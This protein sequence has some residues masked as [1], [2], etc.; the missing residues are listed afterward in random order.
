MP[1]GRAAGTGPLVLDTHIWIWLL[2][3][4]TAELS[5][6]TIELI[7]A[8]AAVAELA[9]A[10]ISVWEVAMLE[11]KG[12]ISLS[13]SLDE[14]VKAALT[15]PGLRVVELSPEIAIDSTR[16]PGELHAD[17]ADR[18]IVATARAMGASLVTNDRA[19]LEY[20]KAGF[21]RVRNARSRS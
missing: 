18:M 16:L 20:G 21:V 5:K 8:T 4:A 17:P 7:E 10:A 14:W 1:K 2:E 6:V 3:G 15:A 19:L 9:V 12:R 11:A 13:R